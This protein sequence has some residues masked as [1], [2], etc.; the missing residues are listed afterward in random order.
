ME[1]FYNITFHLFGERETIDSR[2]TARLSRV[3]ERKVNENA[4]QKK[5]ENLKNTKSWTTEK[6]TKLKVK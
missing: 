3:K 5:Q 1:D 4:A 6:W 2:L